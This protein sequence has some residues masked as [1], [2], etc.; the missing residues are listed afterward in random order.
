[1]R[2]ERHELEY[3]VDVAV[4]EPRLEQ[5][6]GRRPPHHSLRARARVDPGSLDADHAPHPLLRRRGDADQL[7]DLLS[8]QAGHRRTPLDR[9]LGLDPHLGPDRLLAVDDVGRDV[10]REG[11]DEERLADH[12]LVDRLA[13]ELRE[14][15]HVHAFLGGI[16]VDRQDLSAP[17]GPGGR[18]RGRRGRLGHPALLVGHRQDASHPGVLQPGAG[19]HNS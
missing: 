12:D 5:S 19:H 18:Q 16:E 7:R 14:A 3:A 10:R 2:R 1:M 13:E 4:L 11:L 6:L 8:R 17:L 9:I 15:A